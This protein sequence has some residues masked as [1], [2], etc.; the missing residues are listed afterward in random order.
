M[1]GVTQFSVTNPGKIAHSKISIMAKKG[2]E[3][4]CFAN[5]LCNVVLFDASYHNYHVWMENVLQIEFY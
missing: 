5:V 1:R 4:E 2:V 3:V